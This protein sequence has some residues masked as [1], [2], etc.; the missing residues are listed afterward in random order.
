MSL[1]VFFTAADTV[2]LR[3]SKCGTHPLPAADPHNPTI[4]EIIAVKDA[5]E[6]R[7]YKA[8]RAA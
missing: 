5:H 3:C 4:D 6:C 1:S 7:E 2:G 8:R